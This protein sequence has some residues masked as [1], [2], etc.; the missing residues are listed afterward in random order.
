MIC[1]WKSRTEEISDPGTDERSVII[2]Y[3]FF[4]F[5]DS[6]K[7]TYVLKI[8]GISSLTNSKH[9]NTKINDQLMAKI[10]EHMT[11][12]FPWETQT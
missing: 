9:K 5:V 3:S 10:G 8:Y 2:V 4:D 11:Q 7:W 1:H 12:Y 6:Y